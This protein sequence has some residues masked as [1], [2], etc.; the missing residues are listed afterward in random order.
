MRVFRLLGVLSV[1]VRLLGCSRW[2]LGYCNSV[3]L[4]KTH[5]LDVCVYTT[6]LMCSEWFLTCF[7]MVVMVFWMVASALLGGCLGII[8]VFACTKLTA[9]NFLYSQPLCMVARYSRWLLRCRSVVA[10]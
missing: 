1:A 6:T 2:F 8:E 7:S 3:C 4:Y 9:M 5:C 10:K